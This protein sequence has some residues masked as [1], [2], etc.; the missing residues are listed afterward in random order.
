LTIQEVLVRFI[1]QQ[2]VLPN[3]EFYY[4]GHNLDTSSKYSIDA[5]QNF[6]AVCMYIFI[7][8]YVTLCRYMY[9]SIL[10]H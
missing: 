7:Y 8:M 10:S 1:Y 9:I 5:M 3:G 6:A 4:D 2:V